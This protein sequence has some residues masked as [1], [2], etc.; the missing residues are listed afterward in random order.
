MWD[1][2]YRR[3]PGARKSYPSRL[4]SGLYLPRGRVIYRVGMK[5]EEWGSQVTEETSLTG[6]TGANFQR[7]QTATGPG[8]FDSSQKNTFLLRC[9]ESVILQPFRRYR[10]SKGHK[11]VPPGSRI[12][13]YSRERIPCSL[14]RRTPKSR[15]LWR[16]LLMSLRGHASNIVGSLLCCHSVCGCVRV[17]R[18]PTFRFRSSLKCF[19]ACRQRKVRTEALS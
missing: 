7:G 18:A 6:P 17:G 10:R 13:D 4:S 1:S 9:S 2:R 11:K 19:S 8:S 5:K 3:A 15:S 16:G 12:D 14:F